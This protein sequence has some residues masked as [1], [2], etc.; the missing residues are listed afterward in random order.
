VEVSGRQAEGPE[1][2]WKRVKDQEVVGKGQGGP[3]EV[4]K[5]MGDV[6]IFSTSND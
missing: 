2:V 4:G 6:T 5:A 1:D 3:G